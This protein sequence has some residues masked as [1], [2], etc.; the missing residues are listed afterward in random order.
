RPRPSRALCRGLA[1]RRR[2]HG[3][4]RNPGHG[5]RRPGDRLG[6]YRARH[7]LRHHASDPRNPGHARA[8]D[9]RRAL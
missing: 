6:R 2:D 4:S 9:R 5:G 3:S 1:A 7:A 8:A